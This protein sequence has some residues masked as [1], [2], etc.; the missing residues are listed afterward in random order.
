MRT[1]GYIFCGHCDRA[2]VPGA[3]PISSKGRT[4]VVK[5]TTHRRV[6]TTGMW[7]IVGVE[8]HDVGEHVVRSFFIPGLSPV[9]LQVLALSQFFL[10]RIMHSL[11]KY[12]LKIEIMQDIRHGGTVPKRI[13]TPSILGYILRTE[14]FS[15]PSV[16]FLHL[17]FKCIN[18]R[19]CLI[20]HDPSTRHKLQLPIVEDF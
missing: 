7:N 10:D 3:R 11:D 8:R 16:P 20:W 17:H 14:V 4:T 6:R 19:V 9:K 15:N 1:L 5:L 12:A 18:I 2:L 13:D